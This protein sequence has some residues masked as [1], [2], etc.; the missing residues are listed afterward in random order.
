MSARQCRYEHELDG[1]V[2]SDYG[3]RN[4]F[5]R[6]QQQL[7]E[8]RACVLFSHAGI[9]DQISHECLRQLRK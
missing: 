5:S 2:V 4:F 1:F 7:L 9:G 6:A 3:F 8:T